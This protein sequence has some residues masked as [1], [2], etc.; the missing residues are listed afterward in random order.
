MHKRATTHELMQ[1][2][3]WGK[4]RPGSSENTIGIASS[5]SNTACAVIIWVRGSISLYNRT[6]GLVLGEASYISRISKKAFV[7]VYPVHCCKC[8]FIGNCFP[9]A[10]IQLKSTSTRLKNF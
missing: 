7:S 2:I 9:N 4:K 5:F 1:Q 8:P 6:L 3:V 10:M